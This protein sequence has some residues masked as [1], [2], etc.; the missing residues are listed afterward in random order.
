MHSVLAHDTS[1]DNI[2][3]TSKDGKHWSK[4]VTVGTPQDEVFGAIASYAGI[5]AVTSYT[6]HYDANGI[7]LDYAYWKS[8]GKRFSIGRIHRVTTQSSNPQ[9]QFVGLDD[10]GNVA[11]GV[12]IGDY[13][14]TAMGTDFKLHPCWT[15][16]RGKP[17]VTAPNQDAYTQSIRLDRG[18]DDR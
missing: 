16:F 8:A 4:P 9:I 1:G 15:D 13:T 5:T 14:A 18:S 17:G 6:R 3:A 11:Q 10:E 12:F 7:N 2:V